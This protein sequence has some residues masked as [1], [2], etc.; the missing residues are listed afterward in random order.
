MRRF[1]TNGGEKCGLGTSSSASSCAPPHFGSSGVLC[2]RVCLRFCFQFDSPTHFR[3]DASLGFGVRV[4]S[5]LVSHFRTG[6]LARICSH[7]D[8]CSRFCYHLC[9]HF[10]RWPLRRGMP[11]STPTRL[12]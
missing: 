11:W 4:H 8:D 1:A 12:W 3:T 5:Y 6:F 9:C 7:P 10:C 2:L